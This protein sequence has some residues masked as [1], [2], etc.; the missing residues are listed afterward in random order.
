MFNIHSGVAS[1]YYSCK[2]E[3]YFP[4]HR[5]A[6]VWLVYTQQ[7]ITPV[8]CLQVGGLIQNCNFYSG[9]SV[10]TTLTQ[11]LYP[12]LKLR[13]IL[14]FG[15]NIDRRWLLVSG[16]LRCP[17]IVSDVN[18]PLMHCDL[19]YWSINIYLWST[20]ETSIEQTK[21]GCLVLVLTSFSL[22]LVFNKMFNILKSFVCEWKEEQVNSRGY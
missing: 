10:E 13:S 6:I 9:L 12:T 8:Q 14:Y 2:N 18:A 19:Q 16:C 11:M 5:T 20:L 15:H 3:I 4:E 21:M 17:P 22:R 1:C 7:P